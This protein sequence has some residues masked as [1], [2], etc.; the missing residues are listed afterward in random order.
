[1]SKSL[2]PKLSFSAI[3]HIQMGLDFEPKRHKTL[4]TAGDKNSSQH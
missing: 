1:M 2:A 4:Q 3:Y